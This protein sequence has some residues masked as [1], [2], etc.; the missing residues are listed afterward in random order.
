MEDGTED[1]ETNCWRL[2]T[3]MKYAKLARKA[4]GNNVVKMLPRLKLT[5]A[6]N[7]LMNQVDR[8]DQRW[9]AYPIY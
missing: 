6:Y 7:I 3:S 4:F 5:Y 2:N 8:G 1:I 9:A